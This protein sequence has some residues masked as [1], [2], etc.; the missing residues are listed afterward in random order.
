MF[1]DCSLPIA[2]CLRT[3]CVLLDFYCINWTYFS[4]YFVR[5]WN[6]QNV[7]PLLCY[8]LGVICIVLGTQSPRLGVVFW[9]KEICDLEAKYIDRV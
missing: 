3:T 5:V 6:A 1:L 2:R 7:Q 8:D 9:M 4:L